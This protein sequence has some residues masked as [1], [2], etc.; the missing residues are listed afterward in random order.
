[1]VLPCM[2]LGLSVSFEPVSFSAEL[3]WFGSVTGGE[4]TDV[5]SA[6]GIGT[7]LMSWMLSNDMKSYDMKRM[8]QAQLSLT[9]PKTDCNF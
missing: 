9:R 8:F 3:I 6:G 2:A 1:M 5:N 4:G 7:L